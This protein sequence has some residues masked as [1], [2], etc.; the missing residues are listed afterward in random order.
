MVSSFIAILSFTGNS[1][2][3]AGTSNEPKIGEHFK[4]IPGAYGTNEITLVANG[5]NYQ[6][7]NGNWIESIPI[8]QSF[9][10]A[11]VCTGASYRVIL[12]T[13][14]NS[15]G[16]VD[17]E[18][19]ADPA[20]GTRGR[21]VSHP[22]GIAFY[23]P[24]SGGSVL[25]A[26]LKDCSAQIVSNKVIFADAFVGSNGIEGSVTY[27]YDVGHFHQD[28]ML[29]AKPSVTPADFG[30]GANARLE[31]LTEIV[32]SPAPVITEKAM[33]TG[34]RSATSAMTA[35]SATEPAVTDQTLNYGTMQ[36]GMGR[37]F[38]TP[39]TPSTASPQSALPV[40]KRLVSIDSRAVL[41]EDVLWN[42]AAEALQNLPQ[43]SGG[44]SAAPPSAKRT[45][46]RRKMLAQ[47]TVP[48]PRPGKM[49]P[50]NERL[51][52][53]SRLPLPKIASLNS[54]LLGASK[55]SDGGSALNLPPGFVMDYEIVQTCNDYTFQSD[56]TYF[57][58]SSVVM[59][60]ATIQ[61]GA[62]IKL[63]SSGNLRPTV[64]IN[65][66]DYEQ[67]AVITDMND[68]SAGG[69]LG[70][71][72]GSLGYIPASRAYVGL[73]L[74]QMDGYGGYV[75]N[76]DI[77]FF[78][79]GIIAPLNGY[80]WC[81]VYDCWFFECGLGA[82]GTVNS[83]SVSTSDFCNVGT[84]YSPNNIYTYYNTTCEADRNGNGLPDT[85]EMTYFASL[86]HAGSELDAEGN[87]L[88][89]D[90][91][92]N[93]DPNII[94]FTVR[95]GNQYFKT[96]N[97]TGTFNVLNGVAGSKAVLVNNT[98]FNSAVW[99]SY[100]GTANFQLGST[101]GVYQVWLGLK[102]FASGSTPV[103][104]GTEVYLDRV[105]PVLAIT[106]PITNS[107][108]SAPWLQVQGYSPEEL[109]SV[110]YDLSNAVTLVTNQ[111]GYGTKSYLDTNTLTFTTNWFQCYDIFLTNGLNKITV[112]GTDMAGN[113]TST[114][115]NVNLSY[116][117]ASNP[118][119]Q[120]T[121]PQNGM[122]LCQNSFDLRGWTE[123]AAA[124]VFATITD[125][126]GNTNTISGVVER[127]GVLWVE[128]L[129]L[130]GGI[131][132]LTLVV[133]NAAGLVSSTNLFL[134]KSDM[135]LGL[136]AING[137]LWKPT[138]SANGT[139]SDPTATIHVNGA[140]GVNNGDG[141]WNADQ[142]PVSSSG[143]ASFDMHAT[144]SGGGDPSD[145]GTNVEKAA[146]ITMDGAKWTD[147]RLDQHY[148]D[149][150]HY[151][152]SEKETWD[153]TS[154]GGGTLKELWQW[155]DPG[156]HGDASFPIATGGDLTSGHIDSWWWSD[157]D[158]I[159][160][161]AED[162]INWIISVDWQWWISTTHGT[163]GQGG[164]NEWKRWDQEQGSLTASEKNSMETWSEKK[165]AQPRWTLHTG[166]QKTPGGEDLFSLASQTQ[167]EVPLKGKIVDGVRVPNTQPTINGKAQGADGIVWT[168]LPAGTDVKLTF[169][170]GVPLARIGPWMQK[171]HP[172]ITANGINLET[173]TPEFC[174]GQHV[175][176]ALNGLPSCSSYT[177]HW[178]LPQKYVNEQWRRS[179]YVVIDPM[180][181]T[182]YMQDYGSV[183]YR[184]NTD[185][186]TNLLS[187]SCWYVNKPG[188]TVTLGAF[189]YFG[190]GQ[191]VFVKAKGNITIFR[192][193]V[194]MVNPRQFGPPTVIWVSPWS[195][196]IF[197]GGT[198]SLGIAST[199]NNMSYLLRIISSDFRG[200]GGIT[201]ICDINSSGLDFGCSGCL[202]GIDPYARTTVMKS[203]NPSGNQNLINLDDAPTATTT[204]GTVILEDSFVDYV[205]FTPWADE[206]IAVTIAK[207]TWAVSASSVYPSPTINQSITGPAGP[208]DSDEFP[209]WTT[210]RGE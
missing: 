188:G 13:N 54:Q 145:A 16:S 160:I 124:S 98:N 210:V 120:V 18:L 157:F 101:D 128:G 65:C 107:T 2:A 138:V 82:Y 57:I 23:D 12:A 195:G 109:Q 94:R 40:I 47:M 67:K 89:Y 77:R 55:R 58:N 165:T 99:T 122:K 193:F 42:K 25:L 137:D 176:F 150:G 35:Q 29:T 167:Q 206:S 15:Y 79:I 66:P 208:T 196:V 86:N 85:W 88:L 169:Q 163:V 32:Q 87:T 184:I 190:N 92:N 14:L 31:M 97:A 28:I 44:A 199:T 70:K 115:I 17:M 117:S 192:P 110:T 202:D 189:M 181:G 191:N 185:L 178:A 10:S 6:D 118:V 180:T 34:T 121:W 134:V 161:L 51:A 91:Q 1:L 173:E 129:P 49:R 24:D 200:D 139:I 52:E 103:W 152:T 93:L 136:T 41:T 171:F 22:L 4:V 81:Y 153:W 83:L 125:T 147:E 72:S 113:V 123:D 116:A 111:P 126:N 108:V 130:A 46:P 36:M 179:H 198:I 84:L 71:I 194:T 209:E 186:L 62:V 182:G 95:L 73:D 172:Y 205:T 151:Y 148:P 96:T 100:N 177:A 170:T 26:Q 38:S 143:M 78:S 37:A 166:G 27:T 9:S 21:M 183:N 168:T 48:S 61:S 3:A 8:V 102:G 60:Y 162:L 174:V 53:A 106:S 80:N 105:A 69:A 204:T 59:W 197:H 203:P 76:L 149:N 164:Y 207:V 19:P 127:T 175:T 45:L 43:S 119:I 140:P 201:Q 11:I 74:S 20:T 142:V 131:N 159:D 133:T 30:M 135:T 50:F 112:H 75:H 5:L 144:P 63:S 56:H 155:N 187:T 64:A 146:E 39:T 104:M 156:N 90:Y 141:T 7:T 33:S 68:D 154:D 132:Q 158:S 114:N